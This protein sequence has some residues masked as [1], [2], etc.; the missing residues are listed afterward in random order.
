M[1]TLIEELQ[2]IERWNFTN[3]ATYLH[4]Y[5]SKNK[6]KMAIILNMNK[7]I[8]Y[9]ADSLLV[10]E[11]GKI[12]WENVDELNNR[13]YSISPGEQDRFGWLSGLLHC[14]KGF[15]VFG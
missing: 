3:N 2:K 9:L 14:S 5:K 6:V 11:D 15:I 7:K 10:D 13:G 4:S 1:D 12:N 8:S